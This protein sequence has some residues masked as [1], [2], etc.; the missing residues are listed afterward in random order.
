MFVFFCFGPSISPN[1]SSIKG[2][3]SLSSSELTDEPKVEVL[4]EPA[5]ALV[6]RGRDKDTPWQELT[7]VS[8][9]ANTRVEPRMPR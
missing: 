6:V 9:P 5:G 7:R 1:V 2:V 8:L 4:R 3:T